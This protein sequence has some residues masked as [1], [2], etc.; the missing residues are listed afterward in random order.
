MGH[1]EVVCG[2]Q[3]KGKLVMPN[4]PVTVLYSSQDSLFEI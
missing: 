1:N 2:V 4:K 3:M